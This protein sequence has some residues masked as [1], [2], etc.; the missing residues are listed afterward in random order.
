MPPLAQG[1]RGARRI[2]RMCGSRPPGCTGEPGNR[3]RWGHGRDGGSE[4]EEKT[5]EKVSPA[6]G[7]PSF[8]RGSCVF[9]RTAERW[10]TSCL[11][12]VRGGGFASAKP[13]GLFCA[14]KPGCICV[15]TPTVNPSV[16]LTAD[17]SPCT[18]KPRTHVRRA[19]QVSRGGRKG[20]QRSAHGEVRAKKRGIG[21]KNEHRR[22][23]A[24]KR[25][26][27]TDS[28]RKKEVNYEKT[29]HTD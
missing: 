7:K 25:R 27:P 28:M 8:L 16:S 13:E 1:S 15:F 29:D 20:E 23:A 21:Q 2:F 11:P 9:K 6:G 26:P 22:T 24:P 5:S 14:A 18:G 12:C 4:K 3:V 19:A 17:S 10:R